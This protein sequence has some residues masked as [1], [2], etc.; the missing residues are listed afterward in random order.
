MELES[1]SINTLQ[2][3]EI[4]RV[5][6]LETDCSQ[7][8]LCHVE[9]PGSNLLDDSVGNE[10]TSVRS[11]TGAL[12]GHA[13]PSLPKR[14][15]S[16]SR[17]QRGCIE[18]HPNMLHTAS[19]QTGSQGGLT[20]PEQD[21]QPFP[22]A[23]YDAQTKSWVKS[24]DST[25]GGGLVGAAENGLS[26]AA[27]FKSLQA[28]DSGHIN[29]LNGF[30]QRTVLDPEDAEA[31]S[32]SDGMEV[33]PNA[34]AKQLNDLL[35]YNRFHRP[36]TPASKGA[37]PSKDLKS[38][39]TI[40]TPGPRS[41][42]FGNRKATPGDVMGL[43]Q[44]FAQ[45]SSPLAK[46]LPS[47]SLSDRPSPDIYDGHHVDDFRNRSSPLQYTRR[48]FQRAF[49]EPS[50]TY[51]SKIESQ[52]V[53][54][55]Y[56]RSLKSSS[57]IEAEAESGLSDSDVDSMEIRNQKKR[58]KE[59]LDDDAKEVFAQVKAPRRDIA[60][61]VI[62][63]KPKTY[64][65]T[66]RSTSTLGNGRL[67]QL[68]PDEDSD[69][70][71][72][73]ESVH[74]EENV[75]GF[76][77]V[78]EGYGHPIGQSPNTGLSSNRW[79][80]RKVQVPMTD[81]RDSSQLVAATQKSP[82]E[83]RE[84][85]KAMRK[86]ALLAPI[87]AS[88]ETADLR[89]DCHNQQLFAC[90]Q[91][92]AIQDSQP[93]PQQNNED[94]QISKQ[95]Q[96]IET[97][98]S[99]EGA[100]FVSQSQPYGNKPNSCAV[101]V[102]GSIS[103]NGESSSIPQP[104]ASTCRTTSCPPP[105]DHVASISNTSPK[106]NTASSEPAPPSEAKSQS[107][108]PTQG[109]LPRPISGPVASAL[110]RKPAGPAKDSAPD[111]QLTKQMP[112]ESRVPGFVQ[113]NE[114]PVLSHSSNHR[115]STPAPCKATKFA[116]AST[117]IP[118]TSPAEESDFTSP[119]P[120]TTDHPRKSSPVQPSDENQNVNASGF[121]SGARPVVSATTSLFETART[122]PETSLSRS[123]H[124][125][126]FPS[127]SPLQPIGQPCFPRVRTLSEIAADPSPPDADPVI[128]TDF[129]L[130]SSADAEFQ[131]ALEDS[132]PVRPPSK[133]RKGR[134]E[135]NLPR[136]DGSSP[137]INPMSGTSSLN[138]GQHFDLPTSRNVQSSGKSAAVTRLTSKRNEHA[139][140]PVDAKSKIQDQQINLQPVRAS[141]ADAP[142]SHNRART[143]STAIPPHSGEVQVP[144]TVGD[145]IAA[146][147]TPSETCAVP[148]GT[149]SEDRVETTN[150]E[151]VN[152]NRVLA[153]F[154]GLSL[155][156]HPATCLQAFG[157]NDCQL[158]VRFDDGTTDILESHL[159]RSL[160]LRLSDVVK[161]DLPKMRTKNFIVRGFR[162]R[163]GG[164]LQ[165]G[166][167][168]TRQQG[169]IGDER[170]P[171]T[172]IRGFATVLLSAKRRDSLLADG[173]SEDQP[174][175][176]SLS[177]IYI[178][179]SNWGRFRDRV[180][181]SAVS[182]TRPTS[183]CLTPAEQSSKAVTP[184]TRTRFVDPQLLNSTGNSASLISTLKRQPGFF[185][186]MVFAV[187]YLDKEAEKQ[188]VVNYI[189]DNGG[190]IVAEGFEEL[191]LTDGLELST[192]ARIASRTCHDG[193]TMLRLTPEAEKLGFACLIADQHSRK[194]KF[195]Q[196]LALGL[197]CIS[198]RWVQDCVSKGRV[199]D[200]EP[201]LLPSGESVFLGG[202]VRS[203]ILQ[204]YPASSAHFATTI[205]S[206]AKFLS[207]RSILLVMGKGKAEERRR[208]YLFLT[209]ALGAKKVGRVLNIDAAKQEL[210][211]T[212][213]KEDG[214]DWVYVDGNQADAETLLFGI[215]SNGRKR[216]KSSMDVAHRE[217]LNGTRSPIKVVGDEFV[218]QSLILGRLL[219]D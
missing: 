213:A 42:L 81:V 169:G 158:K 111:A 28:S 91:T 37:C 139:I 194:A 182:L 137:D 31:G 190:Q 9:G 192:E 17:S 88:S 153:L 214:W 72:L 219:E 19:P 56:G 125:G 50:N 36:Y 205:E 170:Y 141:S 156:Y 74:V 76:E 150:I 151:I 21:T 133:R 216:K 86:V 99:T 142:Q 84:Q 27:T 127:S 128:D 109:E 132:S 34:S 188:R 58:W 64:G 218:V 164:L 136:S 41:N 172:D 24:Q 25:N 202:A 208:A 67:D 180:Y 48:R 179:H 73:S 12:F 110:S 53:R 212:T 97:Y 83:T 103:L 186:N 116:N 113:S 13:P 197:P 59:K 138:E 54:E 60:G 131:A 181:S 144:E 159:V 145:Q 3:E 90:T 114:M 211:D 124:L 75:A 61:K 174:V 123:S 165:S 77:E 198:G 196:A 108:H 30:Q 70:L 118:E 183:K 104:P 78:P 62:K 79:I 82:S 15:L 20:S 87:P 22:D 209:Y 49:T 215:T 117:T 5:L 39:S 148:A 130:I 178:V 207:G 134:R 29:L 101:D 55:A 175:A 187:S 47:D 210:E 135:Q 191:F 46:L 166:G 112:H 199:V 163:Q 94:T 155:A 71:R 7:T 157:K 105:D 171:K 68:K 176:V 26:N 217:T 45:V 120:D 52:K 160:D 184:S 189:L 16:S 201:Y 152:P 107:H 4:K 66:A 8:S 95:P 162:D 40:A 147:P 23:F 122:H 129:Q 69:D 33:S 35:D 143:N 63:R 89:N 98:S 85:R 121:D 119:L 102:P 80:P 18:R 43:T 65:K 100:L 204:P 1:Q 185:T 140:E 146:A 11:H 168:Y 57:V 173:S 51:I 10:I 193:S 6:L 93:S 38:A 32:D 203:R 115:L 161:V 154:R 14:V 44:A 206:R 2:I 200:W 92:T 106:L 96:I 177:N 149:L 126:N 195:I 167:H